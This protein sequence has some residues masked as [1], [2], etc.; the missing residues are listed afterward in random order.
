MYENII[1]DIYGT[2]IDVWTD[3]GDDATWQ[4]ITPLLDFYGVKLLPEQVKVM[5]FE[6]CQKQL[7]NGKKRYDYPEIDV[8]KIFYDILE[9]QNLGC[10]TKATFLTHAF[11]VASTRKLQ[12]FDGVVETLTKLKRAGKKLYILSNAQASFTKNEL[13]KF[14]LPKFFK[15]IV[16]SSNYG[17]AKPSTQFFDVVV[18]KYHLDKSKS[19]YIGN[20][21][22]SDILGAN[23][24]NM[25]CIWLNTGRL[26][27]NGVANPTYTIDDG[28]FTK[29]CDIVL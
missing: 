14:G 7:A 3:E 4:S 15:G 10:K 19:I 25:H 29:I 9:S 22:N 23:N 17:I 26:Q 5:F 12:L 28:D 20:D 27:N 16:L 24:A 13:N 2:M 6:G 8:V 11:R 18:D 21:L 1:F